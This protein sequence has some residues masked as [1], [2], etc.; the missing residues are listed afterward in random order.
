[1]G[2]AKAFAIGARVTLA[3]HSSVHRTYREIAKETLM[4]LDQ[5]AD[6]VVYVMLNGEILGVTRDPMRCSV[7][8]IDWV[9]HRWVCT[10]HAIPRRTT[11][12]GA[13]R[14]PFRCSIPLRWACVHAH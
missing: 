6:D 9:A 11:F 1:M 10:S 13:P 14:S 12:S 5:E 2:A 8:L 4:P 7:N 3:I